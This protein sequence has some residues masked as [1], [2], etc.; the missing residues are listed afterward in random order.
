[1]DDARFDR[2]RR[3]VMVTS[4][5][6]IGAWFSSADF[7]NLMIF[8]LTAA[9]PHRLEMLWTVVVGY[10]M[11]RLF[12]VTG[13]DQLKDVEEMYQEMFLRAMVRI[14]KSVVHREYEEEVRKGAND[15]KEQL[16]SISVNVETDNYKYQSYI[17]NCKY[18]VDAKWTSAVGDRHETTTR[19]VK[20]SIGDPEFSRGRLRAM[21][22]VVLMRKMFTEYVLP[23]VLGVASI[24]I[25]A[26]GF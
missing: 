20:Y 12:Q 18:N 1:M 19:S 8:G 4:T 15:R 14:G 17:F 22:N 5:L 26:I 3:N 10:F 24:T 2:Q 9:H 16:V 23:Y 11:W 21:I 6:L 7:K 25:G 13:K